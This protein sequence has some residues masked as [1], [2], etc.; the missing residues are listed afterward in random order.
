MGL[1]LVF[2]IFIKL[3]KLVFFM[4]WKWGYVNVVYIDDFLLI[5]KIYFECRENIVEIV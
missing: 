1:V 2:R 3:L 5:S 4:L